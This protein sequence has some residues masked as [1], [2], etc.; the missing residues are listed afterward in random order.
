MV[1]DDC[2]SYDD[3]S[4]DSWGDKCEWYAGNEGLCGFYDDDDFVA[5]DLC[6]E[7]AGGIPMQNI[8]VDTD[9][10]F[11][12]LTGDSCAWYADMNGSCSGY[13][14]DDDFSANDYCCGCGGG[15]D[16]Q[17]VSDSGPVGDSWGDGCEWYVGNEE[18]CGEYDTEEF[19][20]AACCACMPQLFSWDLA[21]NLK[22]DQVIA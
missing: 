20:S 16:V 6:C 12:D 10:S 8:C 7:C 11:T 13:W 21:Q 2:Y 14:D 19:V 1:G 18:Y 5:A 22:S 15:A 9:F 3:Y 4:T 17:C